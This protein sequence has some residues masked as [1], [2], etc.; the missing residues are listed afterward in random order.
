MDKLSILF[1][2]STYMPIPVAYIYADDF[3]FSFEIQL[4]VKYRKLINV[5]ILSILFW[6]STEFQP[7][8]FIILEVGLSILFWDSTH[9]LKPFQQFL[10]PSLSILFWDSTE[11]IGKRFHE[12]NNC[13]QFSFEIQHNETMTIKDNIELLLSIL[14]WDS[15]TFQLQSEKP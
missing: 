1:W 13:F 7:D 2:D 14:F 10:P 5:I 9:D 3:Q 8:V 12:E 15:T 11:E 6:D 4:H